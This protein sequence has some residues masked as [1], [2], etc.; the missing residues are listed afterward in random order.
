MTTGEFLEAALFIETD[1][2]ASIEKKKYYFPKEETQL[3]VT[4]EYDPETKKSFMNLSGKKANIDKGKTKTVTKALLYDH[5]DPEM[6]AR[7]EQSENMDEELEFMKKLKGLKGLYNLIGT[8]THTSAGKNFQTAYT[9]L[10]S[11]GALIR[12]LDNGYEFSLHEKAKIAFDLLQGLDELHSRDIA[13]RDLHL[14]NYFLDVSKGEVN[15]RE[16]KAVIADFGRMQNLSHAKGVAPQGN[17]KFSAPEGLFKKMLKGDDYLAT[18][19]Y[20]LAMALHR[21]YY[22]KMPKWDLDKYLSDEKSPENERYKA[23]VHEIE[24]E[25]AKRKKV[26]EV[27]ATI[28]PLSPEEQFEALILKMLDPNPK[29]R[30]SAKENRKAMKR[31][32]DQTYPK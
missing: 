29:K 26:L 20:A 17:P 30:G 5:S 8:T 32:L 11:P 22:G 19:V 7:L 9:T 25:L 14:K 18:D 28:R 27:Q 4:I 6:V 24:R 10:Y 12:A 13:H 16:I 21:L 3:S 31:I 23:A 1:L 2:Q 15:Q